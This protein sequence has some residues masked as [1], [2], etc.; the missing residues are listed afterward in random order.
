MLT[1]ADIPDEVSLDCHAEKQQTLEWCWA[2]C[3]VGVARFLKLD[4][5]PTEAGLAN[6]LTGRNDCDSK[7]TPSRCIVPA[8]GQQI[9]EIYDAI[10]IGRVG[11][12]EPLSIVTLLGEL[13]A[14]RPVEIAFAWYQGGG[15]VALIRGFTKATSQF[16]V[17]DP[18]FGENAMT[19]AQI[20]N[21]YDIGR[22]VGSYGRFAKL[23]T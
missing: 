2:S 9:D 10:G 17:S 4:T 20:A 23:K 14:K 6:L 16:Y 22:W 5:I 1:P 18:W 19:Y 15:H 11:P 8:S 7:P 21:G 12:D 3:A 13:I